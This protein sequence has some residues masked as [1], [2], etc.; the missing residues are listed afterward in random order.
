MKNEAAVGAAGKLLSVMSD[1]A[2][3]LDSLLAC[4][5]EQE[6]LITS[7]NIEG[8]AAIREKEEELATELGRREEE[9]EEAAAVLA[10]AIGDESAKYHMDQLIACVDDPQCKVQLLNAKN[11]MAEK[12]KNLSLQNAKN[13]ELLRFNINY[14]DYMINMLLVPRKRSNFYNVQGY[15]REESGNLNLLDFHI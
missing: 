6:F 4:A 7:Q 5:H 15:R 9:R 14:T 10:S 1:I 3:I 12:V 2:G 8:L 13:T 11:S